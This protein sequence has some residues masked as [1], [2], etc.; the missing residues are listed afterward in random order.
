LRVFLPIIAIAIFVLTVKLTRAPR[1]VTFSALQ[2]CGIAGF[3]SLAADAL[4]NALHV[5]HYPFSTL[6]Y[7]LPLDLY[8]TVSIVYGGAVSLV[9][10][11]IS[12]S[13]YDAFARYFV[14]ALPFYGV[15]RDFFVTKVSGTTFLVWDTSLWWIAD[16]ASWAAGLWSTIFVFWRLIGR[17]E[18]AKPSNSTKSKIRIGSY[19]LPFTSFPL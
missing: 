15:L 14:I 11:R 7:G 19:F 12:H 6:F 13:R 18:R 5:W 17:N 4:A 10:W 9:Y 1:Y 8:V 2:V 16:F 3:I